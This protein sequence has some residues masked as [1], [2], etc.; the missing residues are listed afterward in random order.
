[1]CEH[2]GVL[3]TL[4]GM[5]QDQKLEPHNRIFI[6][7]DTI[8]ERDGRTNSQNRSGYYSALHCEQCGRAVKST[9]VTDITGWL[10]RISSQVHFSLQF[11]FTK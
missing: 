9:K 6:R 2:K 3:V 7:L 1:M 4:I 5:R 8:P 11:F 10:I